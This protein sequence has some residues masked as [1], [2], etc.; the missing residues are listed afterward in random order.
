M[1]GQCGTNCPQPRHFA[2]QQK[3]T[4]RNGAVFTIT[5]IKVSGERINCEIRTSVCTAKKKEEKKE[6]SERENVPYINTIQT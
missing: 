1:I 4:L 2:T 5:V 3:L 6:D